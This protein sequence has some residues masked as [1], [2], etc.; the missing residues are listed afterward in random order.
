MNNDE[1]TVRT[2]PERKVNAPMGD[3]EISTVLSAARAGDQQAYAELIRRYGDALYRLAYRLL[4]DHGEAEDACQEAFLRAFT[5]LETYDPH[6]SFYTW[7]STIVTNL[8]YRTLQRRDWRSLSV[9][10]AVL[11]E[12]P[13]FTA[14]DPEAVLLSR[15]RADVVRRALELVPEAYRQMLIL[16]HWHEMSYQEIAEATRQSLATVK[17]RLHRGR[18]MLANQLVERRT[19]GGLA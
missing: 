18:Q 16:R 7:I 17:T 1:N 15:E 19:L 13:L 10:P 11:R 4:R 5:R 12:A 6:Y 8:C 14:E 9:D 3:A 2:A